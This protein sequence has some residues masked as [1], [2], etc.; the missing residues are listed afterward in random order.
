M[1]IILNALQAM[2]PGGILR[3][4]TARS[5][6]G[7]A[8]VRIMDTGVGIP[9]VIMKRIFDPFFTTKSQGAGLGLSISRTILEK[10]RATITCD[11]Q[12]GKGTAFTILFPGQPDG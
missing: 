4:R 9:A 11:S 3:I 5:A 1:N 10:H 2:Q 12:E 8:M 6:G 7:R